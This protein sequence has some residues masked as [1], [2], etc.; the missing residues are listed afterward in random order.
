VIQPIDVIV[1]SPLKVD[2]KEVLHKSLQVVV[3]TNPTRSTKK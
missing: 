3:Q 1:A 2:I